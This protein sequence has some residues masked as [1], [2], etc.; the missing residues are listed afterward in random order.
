MRQ[1]HKAATAKGCA[2]A[3]AVRAYLDA[4]EASKRKQN[5]RRTQ[6]SVQGH[7][8]YGTTAIKPKADAYAWAAAD[9]SD[10]LG[11]L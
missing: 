1:D 11:V 8:G 4:L 5:H 6:G 2:H 10:L 3:R 9:G 7:D